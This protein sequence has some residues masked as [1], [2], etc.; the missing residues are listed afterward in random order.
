M[1]KRLLLLSFCLGCVV[2]VLASGRFVPRLIADGMVSFAFVPAAQVIGFAL[3]RRLLAS[4]GRFA[5]DADI[6][7]HGNWPWLIWMLAVASVAAVT[8][9][10]RGFEVFNLLIACAGLP[11]VLGVWV[12]Y[13]LFRAANGRARAAGAVFVQRS[14]AWLLVAVYFLGMAIPPRGVLQ[15]FADLRD[16][17]ATSL[18]VM[19]S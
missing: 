14:V 19:L 9:A 13:R 8:P 2:S 12:D 3:A 17:M 11:V 6:F 15:A 5:E 10:T 18:R 16:M 4:R 7:L 1:S